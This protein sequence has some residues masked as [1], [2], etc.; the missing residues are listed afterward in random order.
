MHHGFLRRAACFT[1]RSADRT[2]L[3]RVGSG[4]AIAAGGLAFVALHLT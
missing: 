4:P 2:D 1:H 3:D